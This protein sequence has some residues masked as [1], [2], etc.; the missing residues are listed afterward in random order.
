ML[1]LSRKPGEQ[2]QINENI[3]IKVIA[4][5]GN[6]V[7]L[8]IAAPPT[9]TIRRDELRRSKA[10]GVPVLS[11]SENDKGETKDEVPGM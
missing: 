3:C 11:A 5:Q 1:V 7:K 2:I 10:P 4:I 8:G 6:R 9:V